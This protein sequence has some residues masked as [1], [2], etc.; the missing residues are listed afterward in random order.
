MASPLGRIPE[1][2]GPELWLALWDVIYFVPTLVFYIFTS[3]SS[4]F[5]CFPC[6][7]V[8]DNTPK[9]LFPIGRYSQLHCDELCFMNYPIVRLHIITILKYLTTLE[10]YIPIITKSL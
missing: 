10:N 3:S 2:G 1:V 5:L 7:H 9:R 4:I 6:A 8:G